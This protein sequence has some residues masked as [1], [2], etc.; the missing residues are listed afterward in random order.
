MS[1]SDCT[2]CWE[3]PCICGHEYEYYTA[4]SRIHLASVVLNIPK[5]EVEQFYNLFHN[6]NQEIL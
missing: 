5:Q 4:D 6:P 1:L 2:K 3:T